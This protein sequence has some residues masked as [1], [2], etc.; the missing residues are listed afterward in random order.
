MRWRLRQA[1]RRGW[2]PGHFCQIG[3]LKQQPI[4]TN[5]KQQQ[6]Q[7][8]QQQQNNNNHTRTS[9][10][11]EEPEAIYEANEAKTRRAAAM[12]IYTQGS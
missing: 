5:N 12:A 1:Q 11:C 9:R 3:S 2:C 7:Q 10:T 6:Q 8:Q 4:T